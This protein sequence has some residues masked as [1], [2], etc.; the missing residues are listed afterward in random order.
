MR[1][2]PYALYDHMLQLGKNPIFKAA[3]E[4]LYQALSAA[5]VTSLAELKPL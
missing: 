3:P 2:M 1:L 4:V 5:Q